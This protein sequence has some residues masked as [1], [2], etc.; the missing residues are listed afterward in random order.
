VPILAAGQISA[1]A[2]SQDGTMLYASDA[3]SQRL[4]GLN[5]GSWA[6]WTTDFAANVLGLGAGTDAQGHPLIYV[7]TD[8]ALTI[9]DGVSHQ[10]ISNLTIGFMATSMQPLG[11]N[12]F[13]LKSRLSAADPLWAFSAGP[14]PAV[15]FVPGALQQISGEHRRR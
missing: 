9:V 8:Q 11:A 6:S 15:Y 1:L 13:L 5:A 2:F 4:I 14:Q 3:A 10:S 12:S 7:A